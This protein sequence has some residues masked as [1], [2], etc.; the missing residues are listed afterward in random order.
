MTEELLNNKQKLRWQAGLLLV[1]LA[2]WEFL[3]VLLDINPLVLPRLSEVLTTLTE[4]LTGDGG[5]LRN[6]LVTLFEVIAA[7]AIAGIGGIIIGVLIGSVEALRRVA[8]PI[9]LAAFAVPLMVLIPLFLVGMG[10]GVESK[11]AF[12]ALY[13]V[14]PTLFATVVGVGG[15]QEI[16][17]SVARAFGLSRMATV[18]KVV[19]RSAARDIM[20]GLQTS[21]SMSIIAVLSIEMFG[22]SAGLG[23]LIQRAGHR[24]RIDEVYG[25][26]LVVL[27]IAML[28]LTVVKLAGRLVNVRLEGTND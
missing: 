3:P 15:V 13:A 27:L 23:Y 12:G 28:L 5:L 22:S 9:L 11:I 8:I 18:R 24:M 26:I 20:N 7:F 25:L 2:A 6:T 16:H 4:P 1:I 21:I 14:F 19:M 10:L 17:Y